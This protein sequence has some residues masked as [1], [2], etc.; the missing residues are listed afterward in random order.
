MAKTQARQAQDGCSQSHP[1]VAGQLCGLCSRLSSHRDHSC[2]SDRR[3]RKTHSNGR[4]SH[5]KQCGTTNAF[6]APDSPSRG[7]SPNLFPHL[8]SS[9]APHPHRQRPAFCR[10]R[11]TSGRQWNLKHCP[12]LPD[13]TRA[14][15]AIQRGPS[16]AAGW[17]QTARKPEA[18]AADHALRQKPTFDHQD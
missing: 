2:L 4:H 10:N 12:P 3:N 7:T 15:T 13:Q 8:F 5:K 9:N 1:C 6:H 14:R 18:G 17:W 11:K 16:R